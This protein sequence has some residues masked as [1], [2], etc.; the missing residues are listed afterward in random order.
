MP[1]LADM[2]PLLLFI[3]RQRAYAATASA[4]LR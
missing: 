4:M 2:L 1:L 3:F